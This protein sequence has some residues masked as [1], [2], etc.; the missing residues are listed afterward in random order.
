MYHSVSMSLTDIRNVE[1][2]SLVT[3]SLVIALSVSYGLLTEVLGCRRGDEKVITGVVVTLG[4]YEASSRR[5]TA[6][7]AAYVDSS[8]PDFRGGGGREVGYGRPNMRKFFL[9]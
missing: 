5:S 4:L 7:D 2:Q 8:R 9:H 3:R 6:D 1:R